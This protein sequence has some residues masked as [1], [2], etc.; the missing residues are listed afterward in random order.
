MWG[1]IP[2]VVRFPAQ[3][4]IEEFEK[5]IRDAKLPRPLEHVHGDVDG[6]ARLH[7]GLQ[8]TP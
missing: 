8:Q 2:A 3:V 6:H 5:A 7:R 1:T 4:G